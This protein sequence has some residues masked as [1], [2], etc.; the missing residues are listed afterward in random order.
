MP[1]WCSN[2][3][4]INCDDVTL[5]EIIE[6]MT[7]YEVDWPVFDGEAQSSAQHLNTQSKTHIV[8]DK[9]RKNL[10]S[11]NQI[12]PV[13]VK[14][15]REGFHKTG[16]NWCIENWGTK[17]DALDVDL[18]TDYQ[19]F[20]QYTFYTAWSPPEGVFK[21]LCEMFPK[22]TFAK[23]E[24]DEPSMG[25]QGSICFEHGNFKKSKILSNATE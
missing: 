4:Y 13:P 8:L 22:I 9:S 5:L 23:L 25:I 20:L 3:I 6:K 15:Y 1:N 17:W 14:V 24:F 10:L 16:Y 19:S 11:F 21:A 7:G 12:I 18:D 2:S